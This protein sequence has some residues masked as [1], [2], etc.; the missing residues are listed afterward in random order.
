MRF[1]KPT[2]YHLQQ[3]LLAETF[4]CMRCVGLR[5]YAIMLPSSGFLVAHCSGRVI[6]VLASLPLPLRDHFKQGLNVYSD[7]FQASYR[8]FSTKEIFQFLVW[9]QDCDSQ[10]HFRSHSCTTRQ[11]FSNIYCQKNNFINDFRAV[12]HIVLTIA[13]NL[14]IKF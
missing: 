14:S 5:I 8:K 10:I 4:V 1:L 13:A 3:R 6:L 11:T 7:K 2:S 9:L 12:K